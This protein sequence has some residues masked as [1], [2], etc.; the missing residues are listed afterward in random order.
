MSL[1]LLEIVQQ[2]VGEISSDIA[3]PTA[4]TSSQDQT[5]VQ[6]FRLCNRVGMDLVREYPWRRLVTEYTFPTVASTS[7]YDLPTDFDRMVPDSH[8]DRTNDWQNLGPESS[9]GWQWLNT[10]L[11]TVTQLRWRLYLN[12]IKFYSTPTAV[13]TMAYEYVSRYWVLATGGSVPTKE[14]FSVDTDTCVFADDVMTLGL[15]YQWYRAKGLDYEQVFTEFRRAV[16]ACKGQDIPEGRKSLSPA[17]RQA[18]NIPE[19][20]WTL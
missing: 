16:D 4:I 6:L 12:Q 7:T 13:Y 15:K 3:T 11:S 5:V 17:P 8:Y 9:Q 2:V 10:G 18:L 14:R 1:T 19:G 20:N